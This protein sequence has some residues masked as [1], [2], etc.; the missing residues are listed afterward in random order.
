M[1]PTITVRKLHF[2][3]CNIASKIHLK[4]TKNLKNLP[5][6]VLQISPLLQV[7]AKTNVVFVQQEKKATKYIFIR[8]IHNKIETAC[9]VATRLL[10]TGT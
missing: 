9:I 10:N 7:S 1:L 3:T 4:V 5:E 8:Q 6:K 2:F